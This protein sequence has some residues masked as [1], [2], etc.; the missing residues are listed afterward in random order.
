V[1]D[2]L[3]DRGLDISD[4]TVRRWVLKFGP[5][6]ARSLRQ[7]AAAAEQS[8]ASR[9]NGGSQNTCA[10]ES[11]AVSI[12]TTEGRLDTLVNN[13]GSTRVI[14]HS[15]LRALDDAFFGFVLAV[16][17]RGPFATVRLSAVAQSE[18]AYQSATDTSQCRR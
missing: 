1:E 4:E 17:L 10:I 11:L 16:N 15:D 5:L 8:M 13:A 7:R 3:A 2:L 9:R 6:T 18:R 12:G 14:P